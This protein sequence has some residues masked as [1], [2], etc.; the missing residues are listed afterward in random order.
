[1]NCKKV[2]NPPIPFKTNGNLNE[3][4]TQFVTPPLIHMKTNAHAENAITKATIAETRA[5]VRKLLTNVPLLTDILRPITGHKHSEQ[6][7]QITPIILSL[8][9]I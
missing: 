2:R 7:N 4:T 8:I 9:H 3:G 6:L 1:M 5:P